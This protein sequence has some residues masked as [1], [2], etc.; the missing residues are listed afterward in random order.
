MD[1]LISF[2]PWKDNEDIISDEGKLRFK[3]IY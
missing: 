1:A 3:V 2:Q